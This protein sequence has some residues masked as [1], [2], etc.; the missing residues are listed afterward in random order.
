[1]I[2]ALFSRLRGVFAPAP[3]EFSRRLARIE[4]WIGQLPLVDAERLAA[5]VLGN[6]EWFVTEPA[7]STTATTALPRSARAFF[8]RFGSVR[9]RFC[10]LRIT[11]AEIGASAVGSSLVRL[12]W[13]DA[14][15]ELC[16]SP[17]A[18]GVLRLADDVPPDQALEGSVPSLWHAVVRMAAILEYVDVPP[19]AA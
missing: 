13:E 17:D 14:H 3:S 6:P 19:A 2:Q 16:L 18:S 1:M 9:G 8:E 5:Q 11:A 10:D 4:A 15:V 12:G 7:S